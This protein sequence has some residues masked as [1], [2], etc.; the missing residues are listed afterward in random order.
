MPRS[1]A[2]QRA[3][4]GDTSGHDR[5]RA[6]WVTSSVD[7]ALTNR[8]GILLAAGA[9][10]AAFL[11]GALSPLLIVPPLFAFLFVANFLD[12]RTRRAAL[13]RGGALP[14]R[15][16]DPTSFYDM[17]AKGL[18]DRLSRARQSIQAVRSAAPRG[19]AFD[20]TNALAGL[21][22]IERQVVVLVSRFD[23]LTRFLDRVPLGD[24]RA[25]LDQL[26]LRA[27]HE[28]PG[29]DVFQRA[30]ARCRERLE[31]LVT[32][33][34]EAERILGLAE[35]ILVTL[36]QLPIDM[37]RLQMKRLDACDE[38]KV[39]AATRAADILEH[40]AALD[41]VLAVDQ[42]PEAAHASRPA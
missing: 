9:F 6:V 4:T 32:L 27:K 41:E 33:H 30:A 31:A 24:F 28:G 18:A 39:P 35:E 7:A 42:E 25:K 2:F 23:Y 29:R 21:P 5:S 19:V 1:S 37:L 11:S 15:L 38:G 22:A 13:E 3:L 14:I 8:L 34:L 17:K 12:G 16:P 20:L 10:V 36:E 26:T 40:L